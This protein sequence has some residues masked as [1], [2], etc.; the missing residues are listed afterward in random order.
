[1]P[2]AERLVSGELRA[3]GPDELLADERLEPL[4]D[5]RLA[6]RERLDAAA[7]EDLALDRPAL[8]DVALGELEIV[9]PRREQRVDRRRHDDVA[10]RRLGEHR[11]H[12]LDEER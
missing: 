5:V 3:L 4:R 10:R 7:V 1:M 2:E 9:E 12:L 6:G 8:E 11:E